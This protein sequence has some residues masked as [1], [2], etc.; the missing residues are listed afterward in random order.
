MWKLIS[1][2]AGIVLLIAGT[3][4][5]IDWWMQVPKIDFNKQYDKTML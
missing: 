3:S 1:L 5:L 2:A 4:K